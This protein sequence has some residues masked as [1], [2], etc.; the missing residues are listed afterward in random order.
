MEILFGTLQKNV[1]VTLSTVEESAQGISVESKLWPTFFQALLPYRNNYMYCCPKLTNQVVGLEVQCLFVIFYCTLLTD[2]SLNDN[3]IMH[4]WGHGYLIIKI[5]FTDDAESVLRY[6][7]W[8]QSLGRQTTMYYCQ[9]HS[10]NTVCTWERAYPY[11]ETNVHTNDSMR[12]SFRKGCGYVWGFMASVYE[13]FVHIWREMPLFHGNR[14]KWSMTTEI[15]RCQYPVNLV[16]V[17]SPWCW[18][19]CRQISRLG[20]S[21]LE[22][23]RKF[24]GHGV[25]HLTVYNSSNSLFCLC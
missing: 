8:Y 13:G 18:F 1:V 10:V 9:H 23:E 19:S 6:T 12:H 15:G 21:T 7:V 20:T 4:V 24:N 2:S 3:W 25:L 16:F 17:M 11:G 22:T 5:C 14:N